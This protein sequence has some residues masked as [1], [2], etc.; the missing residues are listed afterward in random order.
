MSTTNGSMKAIRIHHSWGPPD[1]LVYEE[2]ARPR[3]GTGEVLIRVSAAGITPTELSW[4]ANITKPTMPS[5]EMSGVVAAVGGEVRE[6]EVGDDPADGAAKN[7]GRDPQGT[8]A[9]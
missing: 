6:F 7:T 5:H 9:G 4:L 1:A 3:T 8:S 2:A